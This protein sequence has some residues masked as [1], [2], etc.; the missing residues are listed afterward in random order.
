MSTPSRNCSSPKRTVSG[1][2][3]QVGCSAAGSGMSA[4]ES[5]T[6][7]VFSAV[8]R[9]VA[10]TA[11]RDGGQ[12]PLAGQPPLALLRLDVHVGDGDPVDRAHDHGGRD[13][14]ARV[15]GVDVHLDERRLADHEEAVAHR[16]QGLLEALAVD[17]VALDE[18]RR[19][20]AVSRLLEMHRL[21][22]DR[23]RRWRRSAPRPPGR[24]ARRTRRARTRAGRRPRRRRRPR[25][26]ARRASPACGRPTP[27]PRP[28]SPPRPPRAAGRR[29][30]PPP[31][32]S[33][34]S[35]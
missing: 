18:K 7:A 17:A 29:P 14:R 28:G 15:V 4:V 16:E 9:R 21:E 5:S 35:R 13:G 34:G 19:A 26:A 23:A 1:T 12:V 10:R 27:R 20:V 33:R 25:R 32:P 22:P 31:R 11:S 30:A 6:I 24:G 3:R 8:M 2:E